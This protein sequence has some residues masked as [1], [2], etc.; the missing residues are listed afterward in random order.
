MQSKRYGIVCDV[1]KCDGCYSCFLSCKDEY[2]GADHLPFSSAQSEGQAWIR[3]DEIEY[4]AG[5]KIKVDYVTVMCQHC[6]KPACMKAAPEGAVYKRPDGVVIIDPV[7][8]KGAKEI[9][10]ACPYRCIFWNEES[11][12]PQKCTMCIHMLESGEKLPRCVECCPTGARVFGDLSDPESVISK[13]V[14]EQKDRLEVLHPEFGTNPAVKYLRLP[15]PFISGDVY[16]ADTNDCAGGVM[17][18]LRHMETGALRTTE[19][20]F[21]GSFE[22][23]DVAE[24]GE[25]ELMVAADSYRPRTLPARVK[26][27]ENLGGIALEKA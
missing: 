18:T 16:Y 23:R 25:Y 1:G 6:D 26:G 14:A 15:K 12:L 19:T 20:N 27:G 24:N 8:A 22:F 21:L 17:V 7:K 4:G 3:V 10:D 9:A 2:V 13:L 11:D 5:S